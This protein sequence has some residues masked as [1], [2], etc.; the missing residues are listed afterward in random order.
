[1]VAAAGESWLSA[2]VKKRP[3]YYRGHFF[4]S[5]QG[6]NSGAELSSLVHVIGSIRLSLKMRHLY[7]R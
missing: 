1:M 3:D 4:N 2:L 6:T 7:W 5:H